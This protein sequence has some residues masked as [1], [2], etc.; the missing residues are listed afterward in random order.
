M[1]KVT[2][3][4]SGRHVFPQR[5]HPSFMLRSVSLFRNEIEGKQVS[6]LANK[7]HY[8][9]YFSEVS[10][11]EP[12]TSYFIVGLNVGGDLQ[13]EWR[14]LELGIGNKGACRRY[15]TNSSIK[16]RDVAD[17]I[18][19]ISNSDSHTK[20]SEH[21]LCVLNHPKHKLWE[22][23]GERKQ[24]SHLIRP[25]TNLHQR[26]PA[27]S[28]VRKSGIHR[29]LRNPKRIT[30]N[31]SFMISQIFPVQEPRNISNKA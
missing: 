27:E 12:F 15:D 7:H 19:N 28:F 4:T 29:T 13:W 9:K 16:T 14:I 18:K 22:R 26:L 2:C 23:M 11:L 25:P 17:G 24:E 5:P 10:Q 31:L 1:G 6:C 20:R 8:M 3:T 30:I 21:P